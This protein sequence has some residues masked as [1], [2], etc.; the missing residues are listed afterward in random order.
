MGRRI[1]DLSIADKSW[2][3]QAEDFIL[4]YDICAENSGSIWLLGLLMANQ[5][6]RLVEDPR[7]DLG[8]ARLMLQVLE[9]ER[10]N[11]G[12]AWSDLYFRVMKWIGEVEQGRLKESQGENN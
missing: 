4:Y 10:A 6:L 2:A 12:S 9:A 11:Q 1:P 5:W 3:E 7:P 8:E